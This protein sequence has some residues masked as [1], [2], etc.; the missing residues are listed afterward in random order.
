[1]FFLS[2]LKHNPKIQGKA[3][4]LIP[5]QGEGKFIITIKNLKMFA[6]TFLT[7]DEE[8]DELKMKSLGEKPKSPIFN[9]YFYY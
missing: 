9:Y 2:F 3:L 4:S 5:V 8:H 6:H 7:V 1:M